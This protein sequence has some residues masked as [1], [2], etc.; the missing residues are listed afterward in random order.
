M[1]ELLTQK[2]TDHIYVAT[3]ALKKRKDMVPYT[4]ENEVVINNEIQ[5]EQ[6][7]EQEIDLAGM[8]KYQLVEFAL[9]KFDVSLD[10]RKRHDELVAEVQ[11]LIDNA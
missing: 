10:R 7:K 5:A 1:S 8:T 2:K 3:N 9:E 11:A 6:Q 4:P